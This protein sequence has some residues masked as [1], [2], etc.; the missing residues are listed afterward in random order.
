MAGRAFLLYLALA[1]LLFAPVLGRF[2]THC[3]AHPQG[4]L[5][6]KLWDQWRTSEAL[7]ADGAFP[8]E[9]NLVGFPRGGSL[10]P[11]DPLNSLVFLPVYAAFGPAARYNASPLVHLLL[12]AMAAWW[13][14]RYLTGS[15]GGALVAGAA[16]GFSPF[17]LSYGL[18][19]G[20]SEAVGVGWFPLLLL[21]LVRTVREPGWANP[22]LAGA[23]AF[24]LTFSSLY[25]GVFGMLLVA[26]F[27]AGA[28]ADRRLAR[29]VLLRLAVF[30]AVAVALTLP[31]A[32]TVMRTVATPRS[33]LAQADLESRDELSDPQQGTSGVL[34][35]LVWPTT[36]ERLTETR[37]VRVTYAGLLLLALAA[38]GL[39]GRPG[40]WLGGAT[41]L[42][43]LLFL[44]PRL[45]LGDRVYLPGE[46]NVVFLAFAE[47]FPLFS[48][49]FEPF[50]LVVL[51]TLFLALL[52]AYGF[53]RLGGTP[54]VGAL[55]A[56][57]LV[58]EARLVVGP[59]SVTEP[60]RPAWC[61]LLAAEPDALVELPFTWRG[62][63]LFHKGVFWWQT[64][65]GRPIPNG[66][67]F[68]PPLMEESALYRQ[69]VEHESPG[70]APLASSRAAAGVAEW[71]AMG[72]GCV[73][74][75]REAYLPAAWGEVSG[76]LREALGEPEEVGDGVFLWRLR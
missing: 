25:Y 45:Q 3:L 74:A 75:H 39:R 64:L 48:R 19:S 69:L 11:S 36:R 55:V 37:L 60:T 22:V 41:A 13:L 35:D 63:P 27:A 20:C 21:F 53:R 30:A 50:R 66:V 33:V 24:L 5:P 29:P 46:W 14:A 31:F 51:V 68:Y 49:I 16:Y 9:T 10:F 40:L 43:L 26:V 59:L 47:G 2:T 56:V 72:F 57:V 7:L 71:R 42:F 54:L 67:A 38:W 52:A 6:M 62:G 34:L 76:F 32:W 70:A 8:E 61:G 1:L 73:V 15:P 4:E 23:C 65:H 18:E 28:A 44:G 58:A 17:L 12:A